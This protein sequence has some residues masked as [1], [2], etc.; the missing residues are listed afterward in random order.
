MFS[1][2]THY[3]NLCCDENDFSNSGKCTERANHVQRLDILW[4]NLAF[5]L[6]L[7]FLNLN[8]TLLKKCLFKVDVYI[9]YPFLYS[10]LFTNICL[11]AKVSGVLSVEQHIYKKL[12]YLSLSMTT[13]K[14]LHWSLHGN[15]GTQTCVKSWKTQREVTYGVTGQEKVTL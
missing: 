6:K 8:V 1:S 12:K 9:I 11:S 10:K 2:E 14:R 5:S 15:K 13:A 4:K 3:R 7:V